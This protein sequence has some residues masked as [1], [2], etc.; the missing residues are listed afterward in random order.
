MSAAILAF[1]AVSSLGVGDAAF[2]VG[3]AGAAPPDAWSER[4]GGKPFGRVRSLAAAPAERPRALL[5]LGL[6]QVLAE[7]STRVPQ[8]RGLR[9]G[10][11]IGTSSGGFAAFER[12]LG[13][14]AVD[15]ATC[16]YFSPLSALR[17]L[18]PRAPHR[19]VSV[20]A[21]CASSTLALGLGLRW[22]ELG[23]VDLVLA[24][25]YDAESDWVCAGFDALKATSSARPRPFRAERDGMA[26]GEG[27]A[28]LALARPGT[29]AAL[30]YLSGFAASTDAVHITAPDRTGSA[31]S[32]A[33]HD[34]LADAGLTPDAVDFVSV[35]GTGTP[36]NDAAEG[37]ALRRVFG[38]RADELHL[39]AFKSVV[40]HTLGAAGALEAL[41]A[42]S[43]F[44]RGVLPASASPGA[45]MPEL[46][47][48][49]LERS[50]LAPVRHCLKLSTAF[51]GANGALV[52][53]REV[54]ARAPRAARAA[55]VAA[56]GG[57]PAALSVERVQPVLVAS[58]ERLPRSDALSEQCVAAVAELLLVLSERGI[59]L[60]PSRTGVVVGSASASLQADA[61]FGARILARGPEFAEPR[62]FP[63]TSPNACAGHVAIAF[64][65][66]GPSCTV[67]AGA[68]AATE[69]LQVAR[70]WLRAGDADAM[71][72]VAAEHVAEEASRVLRAL[73]V[74]LPNGAR[75]LLLTRAPLGPSVEEDHEFA[76]FVGEDAPAG[77]AGLP[78]SAPFGSVRP[79]E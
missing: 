65:L 2:D 7:L 58:P 42:L 30:G 28:L 25:G 37:A 72:V 69:A 31:L 40:G 3:G 19:L 66:K 4:R 57:P 12:A 53:S 43:A 60:E 20:Y 15:L 16:A 56:V 74:E 5:E 1:G 23:D 61:E 35:H 14:E 36:F 62:R 47:A 75:A 44:Q 49:L 67:G 45:P 22:L 11:A 21:A 73:G 27:V 78:E 59:A 6:R 9:L 10:V 71:V 63:A 41:A 64:G 8:W 55:H 32:R 79:P 54:G 70:D 77:A 68:G 18:L 29:T 46:P 24:G 52:L 13:G 34:A 38:A 33:A 48:R 17:P 26:L 39:H 50:E 51:G 76:D